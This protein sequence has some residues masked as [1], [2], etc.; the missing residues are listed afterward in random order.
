MTE[1]A[2]PRPHPPSQLVRNLRDASWRVDRILLG[3]EEGLDDMEQRLLDFHY[4]L[5]D[6]AVADVVL[7]K[8][9]GTLPPDVVY[10]EIQTVA[11]TPMVVVVAEN[12]RIGDTR[13]RI[14]RPISGIRREGV[15]ETDEQ[16]SEILRPTPRTPTQI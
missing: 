7:A 2:T 13:I 4:A 3:Q 15:M 8:R 11:K 16:I 6:R 9:D 14:A 10:L 12:P 5:L 1:E